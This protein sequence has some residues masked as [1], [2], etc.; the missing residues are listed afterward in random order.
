MV[1][2]L[3]TCAN[4]MYTENVSE[5]MQHKIEI[6]H[7]NYIPSTEIKSFAIFLGGFLGWGVW[8]QDCLRKKTLAT[9]LIINSGYNLQ[10]TFDN[11]LNFPDQNVTISRQQY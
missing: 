5:N 8:L 7:I 1:I 11:P 6:D 2:A 3:I 10:G 9:S 4:N